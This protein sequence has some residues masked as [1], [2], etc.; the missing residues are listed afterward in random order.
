MLPPYS[1]MSFT[2]KGTEC[3]PDSR[4]APNVLLGDLQETAD[5]GAG[6]CGYDRYDLKKL[7][8][9]W[10]I[11][12]MRVRYRRLPDWRETFSVR[13]WSTGV[14]KFYFD[15]EYEIRGEDGEII[16]EG[17]STWILAD[18]N[19]HRP[20]IPAKVEGLPKETV[21]QDRLVFGQMA[22]AVKIPDRDTLSGEPAIL[23]Y[24]DHSELDHNHH[25]NNTRYIAWALDALY[26]QGIDADR[27]NEILI[28]YSSE[29]HPGQKVEIFTDR[30]EEGLYTVYGYKNDGKKVFAA[31]I[32]LY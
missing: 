30:T 27:T 29:V 7:G 25:V 6:D 14:Q 2:V 20:L 12:R 1:D 17:T 26:K 5:K 16:G 19:T 10:I 4:L 24:A 31:E 11:L 8:A 22:R 18:I 32:S 23:K 13:T 15:R 28:T 9:C 3:G 21:Q